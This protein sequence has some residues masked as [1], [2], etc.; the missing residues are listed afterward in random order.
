M[1]TSATTFNGN[2]SYISV[3]N[4]ILDWFSGVT[5]QTAEEDIRRLFTA[6]MAEN[7]VFAILALFQKRDAR[8][9]A[10]E[11][12]PFI[13]GMACL[14]A[15]YRQQLY[16]L[17]PEYGYL[18]DL[19]KLSQT[20]PEDREFIAK[21]WADLL[22]HNIQV[23]FRLKEGQANFLVEKWIPSEGSSDDRK[24]NAVQMILRALP[25]L[26][27]PEP[28]TI[29]ANDVVL[30]KY[31]KIKS[32][33]LNKAW[34]RHWL[35]FIRAWRNV[36]ETYKHDGLWS[37]IKYSGVPSLSF[38]RNK[39]QFMKHDE[40][41]FKEFLLQVKEGKQTIK[42]GQLAP[43]QLLEELRKSDADQ[44]IINLQWQSV[45]DDVKA[46]LPSLD[47]PFHPANCV[48]V[49]DVS[50][51]MTS[52]G[53]PAP[54]YVALSLA[55]L[56]ATLGNKA[57]YTFSAD[58]KKFLPIWS[59]L[60]EAV[61]HIQNVNC[62]TDFRKLIDQL[63]KDQVAAKTIIILTDGGFDQMCDMKP[64]TGLDYT[65]QT[66]GSD[67]NLIFWN[68][69]GNVSDF[70]AQKDSSGVCLLSG[71]SKDLYQAMMN[72]TDLSDLSPE[73]FCQLSLLA[74]RYLPLYELIKNWS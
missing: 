70:M 1:E 42:T 60:S 74:E 12:K 19:N 32:G 2:P 15:H 25:E 71:F 37:H 55:I 63:A 46:K 5:R 67:V 22:T 13:L 57:L 35:S 73:K 36:P 65:R 58:P 9:G 50:G 56:G 44:S 23:F 66:L 39:D 62:S 11:R 10:G 34:Y 51:S 29:D 59:S 4:A 31:A 30:S 68:V 43:Y 64:T 52:G 41:R 8:G 38:T 20:I 7:L 72:L 45:L 21:L 3:G 53:P 48:F 61:S 54:I 14:P 26:N 16:L 33:M 27:L 40:T 18:D 28:P 47:N 17:I 6:A 69:A 24:W 49:A